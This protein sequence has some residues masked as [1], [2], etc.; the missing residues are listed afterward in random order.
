[1]KKIYFLNAF[2]LLQIGALGQNIVFADPN[3]KTLL[4]HPPAGFNNYAYDANGNYLTIDANAD[5]EIQYSEAAAV[6]GLNYSE[7][8]V[9]SIS[10]IEYFTNL[11]E[12][13]LALANLSDLPISS[14]TQL[15]YLAVNSNV[16]TSVASIE[17][18]YALNRL[19][20]A[21]TQATS[22]NLQNLSM[23]TRVEIYST[24]FTEI[25]L[26]G[27]AVRSLWANDNL[28]L[29]SLI[30]KNNV[31]TPA[32]RK[33]QTGPPPLPNF[34]FEN[35]PLLNSICYDDGEY[36]AVT[37]YLSNP[38]DTITFSTN[39]VNSDC[40]LATSN[41]E[42]DAAS[43]YPNPATDFIT[44]ENKE[45]NIDAV[46]IFNALGQFVK[47]VENPNGNAT[48]TMNIAELK[49]GAYFLTIDSGNETTSK[50]FVKF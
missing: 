40:T 23:L 1:M 37:V 38:I 32:F 46:R 39:C 9:S 44:L 28:Q 48:M 34:M 21:D 17:N 18:L 27:T 45:H 19:F 30:L 13:S 10:G 25:S 6:Y 49:S 12:L 15:E 42:T 16:L 43:L 14:L 35:N 36:E 41:F 33:A 47:T 2:L 29:Q 22:I 4:L 50:R 11:H 31:V 3:F 20:I 26:C 24:P 5:N 7:S 8:S